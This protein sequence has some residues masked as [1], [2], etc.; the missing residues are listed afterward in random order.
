M[1]R[2][3]HEDKSPAE[4]RKAAAKAFVGSLFR[5]FVVDIDSTNMLQLKF[6]TAVEAATT[7]A[8]F[9]FRITGG[10]SMS[11]SIDN[12]FCSKMIIASGS[13][14][15]E[16]DAGVQVLSMICSALHNMTGSFPKHREGGSMWDDVAPT[17]IPEPE[18]KGAKSADLEAASQ[19]DLAVLRSDIEHLEEVFESEE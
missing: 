5:P 11:V 15:S 19:K 18:V 13:K 8:G 12:E 10:K 14:D 3:A 2:K 17:N 16:D 6:P 1:G 4:Q 9:D 7:G